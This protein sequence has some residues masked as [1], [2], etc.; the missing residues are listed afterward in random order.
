MAVLPCRPASESDFKLPSAFDITSIH[1]PTND[2]GEVP[3]LKDILHVSKGLITKVPCL[4]IYAIT[5][6]DVKRSR[7]E[8][9]IPEVQFTSGNL[10][11]DWHPWSSQSYLILFAYTHDAKKGKILIVTENA[12]MSSQLG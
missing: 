3:Y 2:F 4:G 7:R 9:R 12:T 8:V 1:L 5:A 6:N 11:L 10:I